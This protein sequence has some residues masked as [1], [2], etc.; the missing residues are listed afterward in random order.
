MTPQPRIER[1]PAVLQRVGLSRSTIYARIKEGRFPRPIQI[2]SAHVVGFLSS[3]VDAYIDAQVRAAR[4][5]LATTA[6]GM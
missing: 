4:P 3:E 2:G 1:L 6:D 5:E